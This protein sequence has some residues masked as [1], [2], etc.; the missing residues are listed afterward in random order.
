MKSVLLNRSSDGV[1]QKIYGHTDLDFQR[2]GK[3]EAYKDWE[4]LSTQAAKE[5]KG[6]DNTIPWDRVGVNR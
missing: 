5:A 1:I 2:E 3:M 6:K 4:V